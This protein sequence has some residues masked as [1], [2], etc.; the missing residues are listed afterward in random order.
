[1]GGSSRSAPGTGAGRGAAPTPKVPPVQEPDRLR[2]ADF[3]EELCL[4]GFK[5]EKVSTSF[6]KIAP[7]GKTHTFPPKMA[8]GATYCLSWHTKGHC[9]SHCDHQKSHLA[10]NVCNTKA[11]VTW[12]EEGVASQVE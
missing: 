6:K 2:N 3:K 1:V 12:L 4:L 9:W 8:S 11:L 7:P 10:L 5:I